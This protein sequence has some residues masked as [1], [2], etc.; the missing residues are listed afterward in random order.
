VNE[1]AQRKVFIDMVDKVS[2]KNVPTKDAVA[3]AAAEEQK[4]LDGFYSK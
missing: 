3:Q 1:S 2:L 4:L